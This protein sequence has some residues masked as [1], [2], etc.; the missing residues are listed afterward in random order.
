MMGYYGDWGNGYSMMNWTGPGFIWNFMM[1]FFWILI[2]VAL[3]VFIK[4]I[5]NQNK[6]NNAPEKGKTAISILE[7]R[8]AKGEVDREEFLKAK[9]DLNGS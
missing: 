6:G 8:Y 7:E 4:W 3:F 5:N 1:I 9:K 2:I